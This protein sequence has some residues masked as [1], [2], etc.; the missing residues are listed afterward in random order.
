MLGKD[1]TIPEEGYCQYYLKAQQR[2]VSR[3][4]DGVIEQM[5]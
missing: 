1:S 2:N 4:G 3:R 5:V